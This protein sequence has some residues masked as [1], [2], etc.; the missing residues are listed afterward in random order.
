MCYMKEQTPEF[1]IHK[2]QNSSRRV[3]YH[4]QGTT[5]IKVLLWSGI[6][7]TENNKMVLPSFIT[8]RM[9]LYTYLLWWAI[10]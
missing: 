7:N 4:Y 3:Y 8:S 5:K 2:N 1:V 10:Q 9:A 6:R